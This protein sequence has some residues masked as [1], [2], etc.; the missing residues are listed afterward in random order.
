MSGVETSMAENAPRVSLHVH[1]QWGRQLRDGLLSWASFACE[2]LDLWATEWAFLMLVL[3]WSGIMG[4]EGKFWR[5][6]MMM[7]DI[8]VGA[9]LIDCP[10][11][12]VE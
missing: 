11:R 10:Q 12:S 3:V 7:I 4:P 2:L 1:A 8:A 6:A 5:I 9:S